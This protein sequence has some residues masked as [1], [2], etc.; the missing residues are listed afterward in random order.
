MTLGALI[1]LAVLVVAGIYVPRSSWTHAK[2]PDA[3][4]PHPD[5]RR[6]NPNSAN[7]VSKAA[8][9]STK[10]SRPRL[11]FRGRM[12]RT[13]FDASRQPHRRPPS[14]DNS[15]AMQPQMPA[16]AT[17]KANP[18][19][20]AK[21]S[22][23][24]NEWPATEPGLRRVAR[25]RLRRAPTPSAQLDEMEKT[26]DQLSNRAA[27]VNSGLD[28]LQQQQAASG[29]GLRGDMVERQASLKSNLY[30]AEEALQHRDL[31]RAKKYADLAE[32]MPESLETLLWDTRKRTSGSRRTPTLK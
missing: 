25:P 16:A 10:R 23:A 32:P 12:K 14:V 8:A 22:A 29:Y 2:S 13:R 26:V 3:T 21:K 18:P 9:A 1:V 31:A 4:L 7:R 24:K 6:G 17:A 27:A 30:K 5:V 20:H 28:R 19:H 11:R 15:N